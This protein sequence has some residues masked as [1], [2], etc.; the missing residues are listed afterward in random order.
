MKERFIIQYDVLPISVNNY[1]KPSS[2]IVNGKP[3]AYLYETKEAKDWKKRFGYYLMREIKKQEWDVNTTKDGH[4]FLDCVFIQSRTNQ[5][6]NNYYKLLCDAMT[7]YGLIVDDK[8]ILVR[9]QKVMYDSKN[10]MFYAVLRK[11]EY[12]GIFNDNEQYEQF[13]N[14]NCLNC[15]KNHE[16]CSI[17]KKSKEGRIQED[18]IGDD[19]T[20]VCLKKKL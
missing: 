13:F 2:R 19:S 15:K 1:L 8:N 12:V 5:D 16:K 10:P 3:L 17:L 11:A 6:N 7:E 4:W 20:K 9:T 18:I 14:S